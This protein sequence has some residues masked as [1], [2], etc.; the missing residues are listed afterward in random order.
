M[1]DI[2]KEFQD[3]KVKY[4]KHYLT[5]EEEAR[6]KAI[7]LNSRDI[8]LAHNARAEQGLETW[9]MELNMFADQTPE[10]LKKS[11]GLIL[12]SCIDTDA[13]ALSW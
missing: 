13:M 3:W 10:E 4:G 7:W 1:A 8:V 9:T 11:H 2:D 6:R 12:P 5:P